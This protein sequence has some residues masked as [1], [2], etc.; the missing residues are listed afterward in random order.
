MS[1]IN[2]NSIVGNNN[3]FGD[4]NSLSNNSESSFID[5]VFTR[6]EYFKIILEIR[7]LERSSLIDY[8][9]DKYLKSI[10]RNPDFIKILYKDIYR[11]LEN[12]NIEPDL[13]LVIQNGD[14]TLEHGDLKLTG[15]PTNLDYT[16]TWLHVKLVE[17][18]I[19]DNP[20][21]LASKMNAFEN[22]FLNV[23]NDTSEYTKRL[24]TLSTQ[25]KKE[26]RN[27]NKSF[28]TWADLNDII[29]L[30]PNFCG[31]GID[32]NAIFAKIKYRKN[33]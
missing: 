30:H 23:N 7:E 8:L 21:H 2:I 32:I 27:K 16:L 9:E 10:K 17:S 5:R 6:D 1:N 24:A 26:L 33:K 25:I 13:N 3:V 28:W 29:T 19:S 14:F 22:D 31:L 11:I 15:N 18:F 12:I 4:H 20:N